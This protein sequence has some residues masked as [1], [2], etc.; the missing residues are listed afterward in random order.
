MV[1]PVLDQDSVRVA[2]GVVELFR[3]HCPEESGEADAPQ[4]QRN[5]DEDGQDFHYFN[6][7]AL[8]ETVIDDND[9]ASAAA[10]GVAIPTSARG[11]AMML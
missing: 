1:V 10:S 2:F 5:R 7:I 8:R 11:T 3:A 6:R 4:K 9:M